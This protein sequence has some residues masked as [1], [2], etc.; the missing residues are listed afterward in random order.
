MDASRVPNF[1][2]SPLVHPEPQ[3]GLLWE[4]FGHS[5]QTAATEFKKLRE[6]NVAKCKG[7]LF[8]KCQ[9][10]VPILMYVLDHPLSQ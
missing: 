9:L 3:K 7:R 10:G 1:E 2:H 6:P 4:S 8:L 5:L